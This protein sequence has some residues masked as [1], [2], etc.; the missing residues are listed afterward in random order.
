MELKFF[1]PTSTFENVTNSKSKSAWSFFKDIT[2]DMTE[3]DYVPKTLPRRKSSHEF[4][5]LT[6][7]N[8][9]NLIP[10]AVFPAQWLIGQNLHHCCLRPPILPDHQER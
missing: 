3:A 5:S 4:N 7:A 8:A 6:A 10:F 9:P 2:I 1:T